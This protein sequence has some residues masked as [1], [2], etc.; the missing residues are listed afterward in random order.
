MHLT[1][2]HTH[3]DYCDGSCSAENMVEAAIKNNMQSIGIS[4]H[5]PVPFL[6]DW[7]IQKFNIEKYMD[8]IQLLKEKYKGQIEIF[9]GMELD[10]LP[11]T[12]FDSLQKS[13][14]ERLNYY[15]GS[16]HYLGSFNNSVMWTV[17]YTA[18]EILR[19]INE[20]FKGNKILAIETYYDLISEMACRYEPPII[21][22]IDLIRKNNRD[23]MLF[24]EREDWYYRAV[25]KC[26]D[27]IKNTS[28]V[29]EIN[30]G[31]MFRGY[32]TEQYPSSLILN[33]IKEKEIPV[34]INS[35]AHTTEA[36]LHKYEEMYALINEV[37]L[38]SVYFSS[39]GWQE[40]VDINFI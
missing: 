6:S 7:N 15:I 23:N 4:T 29:I 8:E 31:G 39:K 18:D 40:Q 35:D 11:R 5:G 32:T 2:L 33:M 28:S 13:L 16:V 14:M 1:S 21:G 37:G 27:V 25:D 20:S 17:D 12:G 22:H 26:L 3:T 34:I 19:G 10:Y 30:T 9:L 38:K 24:D 36:L